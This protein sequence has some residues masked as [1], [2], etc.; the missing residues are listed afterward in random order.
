MA[1]TGPGFHVYTYMYAGY[2]WSVRCVPY[3]GS[4]K[5]HLEHIGCQD[6]AEARAIMRSHAVLSHGHRLQAVA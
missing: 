1:I 2:G 3:L 6:V 5:Y 4:A